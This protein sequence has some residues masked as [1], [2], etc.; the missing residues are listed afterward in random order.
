MRH[1]AA[2]VASQIGKTEQWVLRAARSNKIPYSRAGRSYFWD[3][4]DLRAL[5]ESLRVRPGERAA[6]DPMRP[7]PTRSRRAS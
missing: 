1:E 7:I 6:A 3:D 2:Y 5:R 4:E